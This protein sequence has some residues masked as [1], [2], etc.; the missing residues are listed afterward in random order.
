MK[1]KIYYFG[2]LMK[3]ILIIL[4]FVSSILLLSCSSKSNAETT[5]TAEKVSGTPV[6]TSLLI[7]GQFEEYLNLTGIIKANSQVKLVAEEAGI[8]INLLHDKGSY[9]KK[10]AALAIIENKVIAANKAQAK[11]FF[12]EAEI[13]L[14]SSQIMFSKKAISENQMKI[15]ELNLDKA[16]ASFDLANARSEK[17]TITAP[18]S[19]YVN[20]R[21]ADVGGY[22]NP[23]S[24]LF[25]MV[26]NNIMKVNIGVAERFIKFIKKGSKIELSFDAFPDLIINS[27][28]SFV[29]K[30]ID[31]ENR[32]FSVEAI[33][34]NPDGKLAPEMVANIRMLKKK[35]DSSISVSI[36]ALL[37]S[38]NGRYVFIEENNIAVK[39]VVKIL[40]IQSDSVLVE[41]LSQNQSLVVLGHRSLSDGDILQ[42]I[43]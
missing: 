11:A 30:S 2:G 32:T 12:K 37:D 19:G 17:L 21:Y 31:P 42:V 38:E 13:N 18:I 7:D 41:G 16:K 9:V 22:I 33:F 39:K 4:I 27:K 35:H 36:D 24:A 1:N 5:K 43:E 15:S 6:K 29:A 25:E 20:A 40:A 14:K 34:K 10:G 28:I 23:A 8:L 3:I 26:D